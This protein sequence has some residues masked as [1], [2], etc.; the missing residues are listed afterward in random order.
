MTDEEAVKKRI[1]SDILCK[2]IKKARFIRDFEFH[3]VK[4]EEGEK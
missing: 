2:Q 3:R 1:K 4:Q